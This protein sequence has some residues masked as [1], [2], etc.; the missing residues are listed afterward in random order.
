M[1]KNPEAPTDKAEIEFTVESY[2]YIEHDLIDL[3]QFTPLLGPQGLGSLMQDEI[4]VAHREF[5]ED[6]V[7]LGN[8]QDI[9]SSR[10][11]LVNRLDYASRIN[12]TRTERV[13]PYFN[14]GKGVAPF[15]PRLEF[16]G[17][18]ATIMGMLAPA[19]WRDIT[20]R[21]DV[22]TDHIKNMT[23]LSDRFSFIEPLPRKD[24]RK[25]SQEEKDEMYRQQTL[26]ALKGVTPF[27]RLAQDGQIHPAVTLG[28]I[29]ASGITALATAYGTRLL[30]DYRAAS[31][32][33]QSTDLSGY[34]NRLGSFATRR[35]GDDWNKRIR[36]A[37]EAQG[38]VDNRISRVHQDGL[39][40]V[41]E[42]MQELGYILV[43]DHLTASA[44]MEM[45]E[46]LAPETMTEPAEREKPAQETPA[47]SAAEA[48]MGRRVVALAK[49]QETQQQVTSLSQEA[50][51]IAA[52]ESKFRQ[53]WQISQKQIKTRGLDEARGLLVRGY[54]KFN[55]TIRMHGMPKKQAALLIGVVERV[56][57]F[58][59]KAGDP[60][61]IRSR[62][63]TALETEGQLREQV[64]GLK[65]KGNVLTNGHRQELDQVIPE[66]FSLCEIVDL[67]K[68]HWKPL[69]PL[70]KEKW[71]NGSTVAENLEKVLELD[72]SKAAVA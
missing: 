57:A 11:N 48:A 2:G 9:T 7:Y 1:A 72:S 54:S 52:A 44:Y 67:I 38:Y 41:E 18:I 71:P 53:A 4:V 24:E 63:E 28:A 55:G 61:E 15:Y 27:D 58:A 47:Q 39:S 8:K 23:H 21:I 6:Q 49:K 19:E 62:I 36:F 16:L 31:S 69:K 30:A 20:S 65:K 5:Q 29:L 33:L 32:H 40:L 3:A 26:D 66:V 43:F 70:I 68:T 35:Q 56:S 37:R 45:T 50:Q 14:T 51:L 13:R 59:D 10:R 42:S 17:E 22:G 25:L 46:I 34:Q 64:E 60:T 12:A